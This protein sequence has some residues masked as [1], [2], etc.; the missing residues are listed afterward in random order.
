MGKTKKEYPG[1]KEKTFSGTIRVSQRGTGY[2]RLPEELKDAEINYEDLG[3]A[4]HGDTV[5]IKLIPGKS[6]DGGPKAKVLEILKRAKHGFAGELVQN[7]KDFALKATDPRMY[8]RIS[9]PKQDSKNA[10]IGDKIFVTITKWTDMKRI[11]LGKVERILGKAGTHEAEMQG[12]ILERGFES[13]FPRNVTEEAEK[14]KQVSIKDIETEIKNRKD[15]RKVTT[16]TID[17]DDAKDFDDALSFAKLENGHF[18]IGI[19][20][21]DVSHYVVVGTA[22]DKEALERATSVYLVDRTIPMLPE[23]L[24]NDLC[25]LNPN[26]DKLTMSAVFEMDSNGNILK[27][28][29]GKTVI[30]SNKRFT[31]EN[32]QKVLDDKQGEFFEELDTLNKIAKRLNQQRIKDGAILMESDEIKFRLDENGKPISVYIKTRGDTNKLIEEFMLL[33]NRHV[34]RFGGKDIHDKDRVFIYRIHNEPDKEKIKTLKEYL[35]LLGYDLA[36]HKGVVKPYE[37]NR[38]FAELEG[39]A[40]RDTIQTTVIRSMQ[41][42]IYSTKNLGHYGLAFEFYTH[43]TSPIRRYPDIISHRLLFDYLQGKKI[44]KDKMMFYQKMSEHCSMREVEAAEAERASIK[45]KQMEYMS[46]RIGQD[47]DG[48]ITGINDWGMYVA[49]KTTRAEGVVRLRDILEDGFSYDEKN[50]MLVGQ[51]SNKVMRIGDNVKIKLKNVN[52]EKQQ[53]DYTLLL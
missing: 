2:F 30:N 53:I 37:F 26:E 8:T 36:E 4:L 48:I 15:M 27:Q 1:N 18:E 21:A 31:Y 7:G 10:K 33:A 38:L 50:M 35:K 39:R 28:W 29:F 42:A 5:K 44:P 46:E 19:H 6:R 49:E 34:A 22:L 40:E 47:F 43:F 52:I 17:P 11:P 51:T 24:S 9:I 13:E 25:S 12:I 45:Y 3:T 16:F 20:I 14:I 32:A 41:K 23:I